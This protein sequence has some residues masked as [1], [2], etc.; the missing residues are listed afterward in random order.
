M[1]AYIKG[2]LT[3]ANADYVVVETHGVGYLI[4]IPMHA[5]HKLPQLGQQIVLHT[6][7]IVREQSQA[8]YGFLIIEER[9][10]YEMLLGISGIGSKLALNV[11]GHLTIPDLQ[12]AVHHQDAKTISKVPGIGKKTAEKMII[13]LKDKLQKLFPESF[14][15]LAFSM[16]K[17]PRAQKIR[18][19][20][21]ALINLGYTQVAAQKAIKH[22]MENATEEVELATLITHSLKNI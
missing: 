19:A 14:G 8:L 9:D 17:D 11:V 6:S 4:Y 20:M 15:D 3:A 1:F 21:N 16:P 22:T 5:S 18:D 2:I 13:E 7:Y 10:L 12:R